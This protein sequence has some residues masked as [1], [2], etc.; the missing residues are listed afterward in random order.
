MPNFN[1][2]YNNPRP[3]FGP[4]LVS[5]TSDTLLVQGHVNF[6]SFFVLLLNHFFA[7]FLFF[8]YVLIVYFLILQ[9]HFN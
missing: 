8:L 6:Y 9:V 7:E 1:D 5:M 4:R 2:F 3:I